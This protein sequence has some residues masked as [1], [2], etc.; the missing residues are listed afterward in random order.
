M[1]SSQMTKYNKMHRGVVTSE[2]KFPSILQ[3]IMSLDTTLLDSL[4]ED[5]PQY[6][7][8][9]SDFEIISEIG[10]GGYGKVYRGNYI[11]KSKDCAIKQIYEDRTQQDNF[12]RFTL[13][14]RT[15]ASCVTNPCVV[16]FIGYTSVPPYSIVTEYMPNNSLESFI[17]SPHEDRQKI[18]TPTIHTQ[19]VMGVAWG[20]MQIHNCNIML[21]C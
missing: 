8:E 11:P 21:C 3:S 17:Y 10:E 5:L 4:L 20:M 13:E 7:L 16:K 18:L 2:E 15:L 14:I 19:I 6:R 12:K 1:F 9:M